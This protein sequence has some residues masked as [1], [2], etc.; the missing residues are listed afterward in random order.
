MKQSERYL[1]FSAATV[2]AV[3]SALVFDLARVPRP[4]STPESWH[5]LDP[6][7]FRW[8]PFVG[9]QYI[10][11]PETL[12]KTCVR[13]FLVSALV[14]TLSAV[15]FTVAGLTRNLVSHRAK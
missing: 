13:L 9:H 4:G 10:M 7:A 2:C 11:I 15:W 12:A 1:L 8:P 14:L 6:W 5:F 3:S